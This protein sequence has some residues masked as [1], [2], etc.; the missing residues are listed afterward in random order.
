M[1]LTTAGIHFLPTRTDDT[2]PLADRNKYIKPITLHAT[3]Q[4]IIRNFLPT[5]FVAPECPRIE[6]RQQGPE[7]HKYWRFRITFA[8]RDLTVTCQ[9]GFT[10]TVF[11]LL[12]IPP[13]A[14]P[15]ILLILPHFSHKLST[16]LPTNPDN[17]RMSA[18]H[19]ACQI[20]E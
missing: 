9:A 13:T 7:P 19:L 5:T 12:H 8:E 11:I 15:M 14:Q 1:P 18:W 3:P 4:N 2:T 10:P 17:P 6:P 20:W 16:R